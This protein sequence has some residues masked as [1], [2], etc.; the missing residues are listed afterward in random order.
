MGF[1]E[2]RSLEVEESFENFETAFFFV[3]RNSRNPDKKKY[4]ISVL[5]ARFV[6]S[7]ESFEALQSFGAEFREFKSLVPTQP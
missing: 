7:F 6:S 3:T 4:E 5:K 2:R 1:S